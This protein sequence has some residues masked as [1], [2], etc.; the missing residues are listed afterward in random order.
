MVDVG[1]KH[2]PSLNI[3]M[4]QIPGRSRLCWARDSARP[5]PGREDRASE[6]RLTQK[7]IEPEEMVSQR[8]PAPKEGKVRRCQAKK[9]CRG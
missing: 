6:L 7:N 9:R 2:G 1:Y 3:V 5:A 8:K 4:T